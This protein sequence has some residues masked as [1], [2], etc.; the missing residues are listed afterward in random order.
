MQSTSYS[1]N[2][3]SRNNSKPITRKR[4]L[5]KPALEKL[6]LKAREAYIEWIIKLKEQDVLLIGCDET[7]MEFGGSSYRHVSAPEGVSIY[8]DERNDTRFSKMQWAASCSDT[9]VKRPYKV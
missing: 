4:A 8:I 3:A 6:D 5:Q 2:E 7:P 9:R 1:L